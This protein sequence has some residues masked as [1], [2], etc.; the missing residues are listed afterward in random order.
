LHALDRREIEAW[1]P[2]ADDDG[3]DHHVQPVETAGDEEAR[4]RFSLAAAC[5][6]NASTVMA[7]LITSVSPG[8]REVSTSASP[9]TVGLRAGRI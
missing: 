4:N 6:L 1:P 5:A 3:R 8:P 2:S 7:T 9:A